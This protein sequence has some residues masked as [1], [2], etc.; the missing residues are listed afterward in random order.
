LAHPNFPRKGLGP[1]TLKKLHVCIYM[2]THCLHACVCVAVVCAY[3]P[4]LHSSKSS[5]EHR[6]LKLNARALNLKPLILTL[7]RWHTQEG[8]KAWQFHPACFAGILLH[9]A[10]FAGILL[11]PPGFAGILIQ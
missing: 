11:H 8:D 3:S 6:T 4:S 10:D 2:C 9:S 7:A 5:L 1:V